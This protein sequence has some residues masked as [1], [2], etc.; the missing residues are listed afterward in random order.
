MKITIVS[1]LFAAGILSSCTT[2]QPTTVS[3]GP[4][5]TTQQTTT[6]SS[7]TEPYSGTTTYKKTTTTTSY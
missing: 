7:N 5:A 2:V 6:T 1:I 4:V 3:P